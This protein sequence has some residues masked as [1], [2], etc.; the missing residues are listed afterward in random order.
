M[1]HIYAPYGIV[2]QK[3]VQDIRFKSK[4]FCFHYWESLEQLKHQALMEM[5]IFRP[6]W[7]ERVYLPPH[8]VADTPFHIKGDDVCICKGV[9]LKSYAV[10]PGPSLTKLV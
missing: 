6:F 4:T 7:Y 1:P 2:E 10:S 8:K 5:A 3:I 9:C